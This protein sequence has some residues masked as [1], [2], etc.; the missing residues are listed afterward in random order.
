MRFTITFLLFIALAGISQV[1]GNCS[2]LNCSDINVKF[3]IHPHENPRLYYGCLPPIIGTEWTIEVGRCP[4]KT[5]F[6]YALQACRPAPEWVT[7]CCDPDE[8]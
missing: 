7:M 3:Q 6:N 1:T 5:I 4:C 8:F 2:N